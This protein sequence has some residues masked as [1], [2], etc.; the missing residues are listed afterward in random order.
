MLGHKGNLVCIKA[1]KPIL[2]LSPDA[3]L[4]IILKRHYEF[5]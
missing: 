4:H 2:A 1:N 5:N 3:L